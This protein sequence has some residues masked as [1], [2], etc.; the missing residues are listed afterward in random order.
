MRQPRSDYF[1]AQ[2]S[3]ALGIL[4]AAAEAG[5]RCPTRFDL[6]D[7]GI[8][9]PG[10]HLDDLIL[11]G[12][13]RVEVYGHNFRV[14][15]IMEG[16]AKGKRTMEAPKGYKPHLIRTKDNLSGRTPK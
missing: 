13:I 14:V 5:E 4:E 7:A 10:K 2:T 1:K 3:R 16:K 9:Q 8:S 15:E 6:E 11:D 12:L